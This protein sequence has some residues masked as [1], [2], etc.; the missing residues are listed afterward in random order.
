MQIDYDRGVKGL[1]AAVLL[2]HVGACSGSH[3]VASPDAWAADAARAADAAPDALAPDATP[4]AWTAA[5]AVPCADAADAPYAVTA[6]PGQALGQI[7][8]C[9]PIETMTQADAQARLVAAAATGAIATTGVTVWKIAYATRHSSGAPAVS[10]ALVFLPVTPS[11]TPAGRVAMAHSTVGLADGCAPSADATYGSGAIAQ[12]ALAF[13]AR[14][15]AVIAPDLSGLGNDGVQAYLD[16]R[17]QGLQLLDGSRALAALLAPGAVDDS[18]LLVGYSQGGGTVLSAQALAPGEAGAGRVI[19]TIAFA[20]EWPIGAGSFGYSAMLHA[21]DELTIQTGLSD[22]SVAVMR[23]YAWG[24]AALGPGHGVDLFPPALRD[25]VN[26]VVTSQCLGAVGAWVQGDMLHAGDL[27]DPDV[28]ASVVACLDGGAGDPGCTGTGRA[29]WQGA[30]AGDPLSGS[31][32]GG[33]V[34]IVQGLLDQIMP[35]ASEASCDAD[36]LRIAGVT[37]DTCL[38]LGADH[39]SIIAAQLPA[40]LAWADAAVAG[41]SRP[42]CA[43]TTLPACQQ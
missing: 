31:P 2:A 14:G 7:L 13:A 37:V 42:A 8:S 27:I 29:Y 21:P 6:A 25:G 17:E 10:T 43:A 32:D 12:V 11:S 15:R 22:S 19:G 41:T 4:P 35:A 1:A 23:Q 30:I 16:N 18:L 26:G 38:D 33:P 36:A 20:P 9:A 3:G 28:R 40:A 39:L 34:L 24:E 5:P